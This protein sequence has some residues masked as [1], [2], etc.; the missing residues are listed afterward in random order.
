MAGASRRLPLTLH[1]SMRSGEAGA[2]RVPPQ[3]LSSAFTPS[4]E[5]QRE[6]HP[7]PELAATWEQSRHSLC[8]H[9]HGQV[10]CT[11]SPG[12]T[13]VPSC[14]LQAQVVPGRMLSVELSHELQK[15]R[16][17]APAPGM[18]LH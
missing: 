15:L 16:V 6:G 13:E 14:C 2:Q 10:S 3:H 8:P 11:R 17:S 4:P 5:K 12:D 7:I 1:T 18:P 9:R